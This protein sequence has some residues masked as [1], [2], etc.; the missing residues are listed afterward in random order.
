MPHYPGTGFPSETGVGNIVNVPLRAGEDGKAFADKYQSHILPR[1]DSFK[2]EL[3]LISA[4]F[5]AHKDDPLAGVALLEAD[6]QWVTRELMAIADR[7]CRGRII[8][9]LEGGY[10]LK[11]LESSV[12]IHVEALLGN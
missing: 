6:Y 5:D 4:G 9:V 8:S 7:H 10:N 12:A 2:P 1:V 11:A 3:I